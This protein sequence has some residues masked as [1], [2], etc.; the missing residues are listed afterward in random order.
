[1]QT[2]CQIVY[3]VIWSLCIHFQTSTRCLFSSVYWLTVPAVILSFCFLIIIM[4]YVTFE[5]GS[6]VLKVEVSSDLFLKKLF[7]RLLKLPGGFHVGRCRRPCLGGGKFFC[8]VF[9]MPF[10]PVFDLFMWMLNKDPHYS[11]LL[12]AGVNNISLSQ[13]CSDSYT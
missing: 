1:M 8:A 13:S 12:F 11:L 3:H 9:R 2:L 7:A 6:I 5:K 10:W 4:K